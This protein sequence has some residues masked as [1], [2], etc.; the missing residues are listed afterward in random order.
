MKYHLKTDYSKPP[1]IFLHGASYYIRRRLKIAGTYKDVWRS[2]RTDNKKEAEL[3]AYRL[4]YND[5]GKE[6]QELLAKPVIEIIRVFKA[7]DETERFKL[8][9][10]STRRTIECSWTAFLVYCDQHKRTFFNE[11]DKEFCIKFLTRNEVKNKTFN[12]VLNDMKQI[13]KPFCISQKLDNPFVDIEQKSITR[14]EK[15]SDSYRMFTDAEVLKIFKELPKS[16]IHHK[17][18]WL[19]ACQIAAYTGLRYKDIA[20]LQWPAITQKHITIIPAK[21]AAKTGNRK[22]IILL[23]PKLKEIFA[24]IEKSG[25]P[26]FPNLAKE[27]TPKDGTRAFSQFLKRIGIVAING[28]IAG[29]HSFR[30]TFITKAKQSG[31]S[32]E[33]IGGIVGHT[34]ANQTDVYNKDSDKIDI[35]FVKYG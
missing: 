31:I 14:G 35:S 28:Q 17:G 33:S 1:K 30:A 22:V 20:L 6:A 2:L 15:A 7:Y 3:A 19:N 8:L 29:F 13:F 12:N 32:L 16:N 11:L 23:T 21:T 25:F 27:Y 5:Q 18:E 26:L 34:S 4:W 10:D 9:S 24:S